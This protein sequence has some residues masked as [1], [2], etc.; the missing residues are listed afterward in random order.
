MSLCISVEKRN[1]ERV[2][3]ELIRRGLIDDL[4]SITRSGDI[5]VIPVKKTAGDEITIDTLK[6]TVYTCN[7]P[8]RRGF[9][10]VKLPSLDVIG[11][12]IVVREKAADQWDP[13]ELITSIK[14]IYPR[15]KAIWIQEKTID[16]YRIPV[17]KLLWGEDKRDVVV[18]E[19]GLRLRVRLGEVYFNPRLAGEHHEIA[20]L[21]NDGEVVVDAFCGIGGYALHIVSRRISLVVANDVNPVAYELLIDNIRMN[22]RALRG[23]VIPVNLDTREL[24][25]VIRENSVDRVIA[26]LPMW[27]TEFYEIYDL[28]LKPGGTLHLYRVSEGGEPVGEVKKVFRDWVLEKC[29]LVSEYAP[30]IGI[31]R[32][33]LVKPKDI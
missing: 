21:V 16:T 6:Y 22:S 7:P 4:Y 5:V 20:S 29:K 25:R 27:S 32:C 10:K 28:L 31:Y 14:K 2:I 24:P 3:G 8:P 9:T 26:D 19:Y 17:L 1:A 18:K 23:V 30:R 15:V 12:V 11:D 13:G 33:D